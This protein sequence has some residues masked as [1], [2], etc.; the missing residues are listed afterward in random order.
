MWINLSSR[1]ITE[2]VRAA[3]KDVSFRAQ[4]V[5][6]TSDAVVNFF[7]RNEICKPGQ[8]WDNLNTRLPFNQRQTT[9]QHNTQTH[10][11]SSCHF[12]V[13]KTSPAFLCRKRTAFKFLM[14]FKF[15]ITLTVLHIAYAYEV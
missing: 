2:N 5:T 7:A 13:G 8:N 3:V 14:A 6:T 1:T 15:L 4:S 11:Y 12:A 9:H 10:F